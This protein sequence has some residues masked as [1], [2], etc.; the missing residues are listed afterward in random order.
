MCIIQLVTPCIKHRSGI[1]EL[2][3]EY[4]TN[5]EFET[6]WDRA[7][8]SATNELC[9]EESQTQEY[10]HNNLKS[11]VFFA[12]RDTDNRLIGIVFIKH[13]INKFSSI[14]ESYISYSIRPSE[15]EAGYST[16]LLGL[17]F[18]YCKN[19]GITHILVKCDKNQ[20]TDFKYV[21]PHWR[22]TPHSTDAEDGI[23]FRYYLATL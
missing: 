17:S 22:G 23:N 2:I 12:T 1:T 20:N 18:N 10:A 19:M 16:D 21:N 15:R 6:L 8:Y 5:G 13:L 11:N 4:R 7:I 14:L 3:H 9:N